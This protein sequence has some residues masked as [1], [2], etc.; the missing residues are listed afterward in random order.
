MQPAAV[1]RA[2]VQHMAVPTAIAFRISATRQIPCSRPP[3]A[4]GRLAWA[5]QVMRA[6]GN[7]GVVRAK[8]RKNLPPSSMV[9][10]LHIAACRL[11]TWTRAAGC[12][13]FQIRCLAARL[14]LEGTVS[15]GVIGLTVQGPGVT[16]P[17]HCGPDDWLI[18]LDIILQGGR[19]RVML[20]PSR[21]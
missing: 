1:L 12:L 13:N 3:I 9:S 8:F 17:A 11:M 2:A 4:E 6:H 7:V 20:Y 5:R 21:V 19:V 10:P 18:A 16:L 15:L 14:V